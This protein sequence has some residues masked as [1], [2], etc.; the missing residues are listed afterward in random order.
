MSKH[1]DNKV[2]HFLVNIFN[3]FYVEYTIFLHLNNNIFEGGN[4]SDFKCTSEI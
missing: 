2:G 4:I 3:I 1:S